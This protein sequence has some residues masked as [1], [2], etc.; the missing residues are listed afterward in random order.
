MSSTFDMYSIESVRPDYSWDRG[1]PYQERIPMMTGVSACSASSSNSARIEYVGYAPF[2]FVCLSSVPLERPDN[3]PALLALTRTADFGDYYNNESN[4][5]TKTTTL[6]AE[7]FCHVYV[8]PGLYSIKFE[9]TEY[10][11]SAEVEPFKG[12]GACLQKYC[13]DWSWKKLANCIP[14]SLN[15]TW[16]SAK[17]GNPY[18]KTWK[19]QPC[20]VDWASNNGLYIQP[21]GQEEIN[22]LSWQWYNY[23]SNLKSI[24]NTH[25]T[26]VKWEATGFQ[27][28]NQLTWSGTTGP[29]LNIGQMRQITWKWNNI[30][31][32]TSSQF[33]SGII[34]DYLKETEPEA[35]T[36]DYVEEFQAGTFVPTLSTTAVSVTKEAI[37]RVLEILP[38]AYLIAGSPSK[39]EAPISN[40]IS[41]LTVR[42]SPKHTISGSF[43]IEKI[44]WDL[45][46]GSPLLIQRR[47][48][49]N[50]D[51]PFVYTGAISEDYQDPRNYDVIH[52]YIKTPDTGFSF[53]P[54]I[55][56]YAS[57]THSS[58]CAATM[59]GPLVLDQTTG[60]NFKLMQTD[61]TEYGKVLIGQVDN[62]VAIWRADK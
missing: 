7:A 55:T 11:E 62:N 32:P 31:N 25:N 56:A 51:A 49:I 42:L 12:Y 24:N 41:P 58:D 6:S 52:T 46:D 61:L 47:W 27:Q 19:Y 16:L 54:S 23:K 36:W 40:R 8:M 9:H 15:V 10:M 5:V 17:S 44:V 20:E 43:P 48:S 18:Q 53:Y 39:V 33:A 60:S 1:I 29:C 35:T 34:W 2:V 59:V 4:I 14:T 22:P 57:N 30:T 45:G 38:Q 50:L 3:A 21:M 26:P 37:I 13:I 28:S